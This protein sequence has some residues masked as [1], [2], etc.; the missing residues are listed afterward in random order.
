ML[1]HIEKGKKGKEKLENKRGISLF[2]NNS[3]LFEKIIVN[4]L[5]KHLNFTEA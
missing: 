5:N 1:I 3:N 4:R 2:N